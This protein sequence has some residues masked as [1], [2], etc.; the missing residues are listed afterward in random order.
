MSSPCAER[1]AKDTKLLLRP[2]HCVTLP[3]LT[4]EKVMTR[5][6]MAAA[7]HRIDRHRWCQL[8]CP[9]DHLPPST[10][11]NEKRLSGV[12]SEW[13]RIL[14]HVCSENRQGA[15]SSQ[16]IQRLSCFP[17]LFVAI[18]ERKPVDQM[19]LFRA[20]R[21]TTQKDPVPCGTGHQGSNQIW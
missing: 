3:P 21:S 17:A 2:R 5:T 15:A 8:L 19:L 1:R 10:N 13:I 12:A 14:F 11:R 16:G 18:H 20:S 4:I 7:D 9:F 6:C